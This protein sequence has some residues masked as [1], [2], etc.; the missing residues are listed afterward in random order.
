MRQRIE[1]ILRFAQD[2]NDS[3]MTESVILSTAKD[4]YVSSLNSTK[5]ENL[6]FASSHPPSLVLH[7]KLGDLQNVIP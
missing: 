4:L 3:H 7:G 6:R 5:G 2:D 1:Q